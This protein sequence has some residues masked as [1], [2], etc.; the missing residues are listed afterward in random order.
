[1]TGKEIDT[2]VRSVVKKLVSEMSC[3]DVDREELVAQ[4]YLIV[5]EQIDGYDKSRGTALRTWLYTQLYNRLKNYIV[6]YIYSN[7]E[8]AK[9][10]LEDLIGESIDTRDEVEARLI[11]SKL[12][13]SCSER[14]RLIIGYLLEGLTYDEIAE[15]MSISKSTIT[16]SM[17]KWRKYID[18][19]SDNT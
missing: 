12:L 18:G 4:G 3:Y 15:K 19:T 13:S 10:P 2:L 16:Y 7:T 9:V 8:R 11:I 14:D 5:T 1:M 17:G 6:R